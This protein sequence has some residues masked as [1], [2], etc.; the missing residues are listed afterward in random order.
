VRV[1]EETRAVE[2]YP[3]E[4][5]Q[6]GGVAVTVLGSIGLAVF[7]YIMSLIFGSSENWDILGAF[8]IGPALF[9]FTVP[10]L[11]R[12]ARREGDKMLM[13]LLLLALALKLLGAFVRYLI[14]TN[15][16]GGGVD[17]SA[18]DTEGTLL[19]EGFRVGDF[20]GIE[21]TTGTHFIELIT[22][23]LYTV[24]GPS[25]LGGYVFFSWLAFLGLFLFYRAFTIAVP[26]GRRRTYARFVFFLPS[27]LVWPS[28]IGKEAWMVLCLGII[29][30]GAAR[31]LSGKTIKGLPIAAVGLW[32]AALPRGHIA[33]MAGVALG[34]GLLFRR[35]PQRLRQLG[36]ILKLVSIGLVAAS[37]VFFIGQGTEFID[38][39]G[40]ETE[41]GLT[42]S[43]DQVADRTSGGKSNFEAPV[44]T[45]PGNAPLAI[46]TVLYRPTVADA[47]A[48]QALL[49][50]LEG[51]FLFFLTIAR[52]RW[53]TAA[54]R[55]MRRR[56]YIAFSLA[57]VGGLIIVL[58][59]VSNLGI[60]ARERVQLLPFFFV[61]LS[62]PSKGW[63]EKREARTAQDRQPDP[64]TSPAVIA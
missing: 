45:S 5:P 48:P 6:K 62:I 14:G 63:L 49:A 32:M 23:L 60:L 19:A 37:A 31:I 11:R 50:A 8:I 35:P 20:S 44:L 17:A 29:A 40:I 33:A 9:A 46:F 28:S 25:R 36:P 7:F 21:G 18:Y 47:H 43:L 53:M 56:P 4:I 59:A 64:A 15:V 27:L 1:A 57:M 61:L 54:F 38:K 22:G 52:F 26:E 42:E 55:L 51:T 41:G 58:S 13:N 34:A 12:Q 16:Y 39:A 24:M 10:M 30:F 2:E 3:A